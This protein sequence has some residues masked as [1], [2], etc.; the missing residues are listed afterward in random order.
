MVGERGGM[1]A[2]LLCRKNGSRA[3]RGCW[4]G[5]LAKCISEHVRG[6]GQRLSKTDVVLRFVQGLLSCLLTIRTPTFA[7][8]SVLNGFCVVFR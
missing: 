2:A 4:G 5:K 6:A 3:R 7:D 1:V 8:V